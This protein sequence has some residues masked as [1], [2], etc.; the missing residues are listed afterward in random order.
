MKLALTLLPLAFTHLSAQTPVPERGGNLPVFRTVL[1][2]RPRV[3]VIR[4][5]EERAVAFDCENGLLWKYW[6]AEPGQLPVKLQGAVYNGA[7]GPQPVSQGKIHFIDDQP[8][9]IPSAPDARLRYLGHLSHSDGTTTVRWSF[10]DAENK[11]LATVSVKPTFKDGIAALDYKL[12][13][14]P[15][16]G[17][18]VML[19]PPGTK[20]TPKP[21]S[22]TP[23]QITLK[24]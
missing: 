4:L 6:Q 24:P 21:L 2:E 18:T 20:E 8:Q 11:Q 14:E 17:F 15:A 9:L 19:R 7:H 22:T 12:E 16:S 3:I 5:G 1:D 10:R 23:L 13:A